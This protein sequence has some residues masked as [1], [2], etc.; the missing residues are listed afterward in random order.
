[1]LQGLILGPLLFRVYI[2]DLPNAVEHKTHTI[3][4]ADD[5]SILL[6]TPNINIF[7]LQSDLKLQTRL[8]S[9]EGLC[10]ME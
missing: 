6:T 5:T 3:L 9:Q 2:N 1:M 7:Q 8:A 10:S 4:F